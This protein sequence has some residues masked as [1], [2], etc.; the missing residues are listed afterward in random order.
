MCSDHEVGDDMLS[1]LDTRSTLVTVGVL[2]GS[3]LVTGQR[4]PSADVLAPG[5]ARPIQRVG[6]RGLQPKAR[7]GEEPVDI[8][9]L[10]EVDGQLGVYRVA[11][12]DGSRPQNLR[13]GALRLIAV[14]R[15]GQ[16]TV[17][18]CADVRQPIGAAVSPA[19]GPSSEALQQGDDARAAPSL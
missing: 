8:F 2:R 18:R 9:L 13:Q 14:G 10:R 16:R 7:I 17:V 5:C 11:D 12:D 4:R 19:G 15:I 1:G 6:V 3:T